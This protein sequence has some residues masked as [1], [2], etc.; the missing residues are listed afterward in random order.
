VHIFW[1]RR[2]REGD[3]TTPWWFPAKTDQGAMREDRLVLPI[4]PGFHWSNPMPVL[5]SDT[6]EAPPEPRK[7]ARSPEVGEKGGPQEPTKKPR[8]GVQ[9][10]V[11]TAKPV[12]AVEPS[13][14]TSEPKQKPTKPQRPR[15]LID[16]QRVSKARELRDRYLEQ[17]NAGAF[18][19]ESR[20]RYDVSRAL[21]A[22]SATRLSSS[23]SIREAQ[24]AIPLLPAA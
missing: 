11:P 22:P 20:G 3:A 8:A 2:I 12:V 23:K 19:L 5:K 13:E 9:F 17:V 21:P 15:A 10:G 7:R 16:P 1:Q 4:P 14:P 6:P 18:Q 24:P